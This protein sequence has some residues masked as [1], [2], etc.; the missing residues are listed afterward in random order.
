MHKK[1][2]FIILFS[3]GSFL[4]AQQ[5]YD[6]VEFVGFINTDQ[7]CQLYYTKLNKSNDTIVKNIVVEKA[8]VDNNEEIND[9]LLRS[10]LVDEIAFLMYT[11]GIHIL[12]D[13]FHMFEE[14]DSTL[15][16]IKRSHQV[17]FMESD[18]GPFVWEYKDSLFLK[19]QYVK[20]NERISYREF[21]TNCFLLVS[22]TFR[23]VFDKQ[24]QYSMKE[25]YAPGY[26]LD[27]YSE[28]KVIIVI[29]LICE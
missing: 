14:D 19:S 20:I 23:T 21:T 28:K 10:L 6:P 12:A 16:R 15:N 27:P 3:T 7:L 24:P 29:P 13:V 8:V 18:D 1:I 25:G 9:S 11:N 22:T 5:L 17:T 4:F 2:L 26:W